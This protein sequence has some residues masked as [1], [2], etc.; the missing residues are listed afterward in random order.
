MECRFWDLDEEICFFCDG[1]RRRPFFPIVEIEIERRRIEIEIEL[2][3]RRRFEIE[4]RRR[5]RF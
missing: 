2:E 3:R 5:R 1:F 4:R